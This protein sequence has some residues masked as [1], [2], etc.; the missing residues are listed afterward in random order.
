MTDVAAG[1]SS[2]W[3]SDLA[4][5]L[6]HRQ[7]EQFL[8]HEASLMDSHQYQEW[9]GLWAEDL[10]YW[11]PCNS[12]T[13][14]PVKQ[15]SII[16]DK[17]VDLEMRIGRLDGRHA[18]AQNPKSRL[19]RVISNIELLEDGARVIVSS[20]FVLGEVRMKHQTI[21]FGRSEH[22]LVPNGGSF[23]ISQKKVVLLENDMQ[24]PNI[25]YLL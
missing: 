25:I 15:I 7:V 17:R 13:P 10:L 20:K 21:L 2:S 4:R 12:D 19:Q 16:Y 23:R 6:R 14:D 18:H 11:V 8:V 1:V 22:I 24:L 5:L 3:N 9:L